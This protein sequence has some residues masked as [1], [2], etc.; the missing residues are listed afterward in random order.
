ML[1]FTLA[2]AGNIELAHQARLLDAQ[3]EPIDGTVDLAVSLWNSEMGTAPADLAWRGTFS[4]TPVSS[5]YVSV[6][7][8]GTDAL[9]SSVLDTPELWVQH[10]LG[11]AL[12]GRS[13]LYRV[14]IAEVANR[15]PVA[16]SAGGSCDTEGALVFDRSA[17]ALRVCSGTNWLDVTTSAARSLVATN[18]VYAWSDGSTA[19]SCR[20]YLEDTDYAGEGDGMYRIDASGGG[21]SAPV[22]AYCDMTSS[23][24]GWTLIHHGYDGNTV[25]HGTRFA[26]VYDADVPDPLAKNDS[27]NLIPHANYAL[28]TDAEE[29]LFEYRDLSGQLAG[30]HNHQRVEAEG[31]F[32]NLFEASNETNFVPV[33]AREQHGSQRVVSSGARVYWGTCAPYLTAL[34]FE[35]F[36]DGGYHPTGG[37]ACHMNTYGNNG[38]NPA[39]LDF[40]DFTD[41]NGRGSGTVGNQGWGVSANAHVVNIWVR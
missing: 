20:A 30:P 18:G 5:G 27:L 37:G 29:L 32:T 11:A 2:F 16:A 14:P 13:L 31:N 40:A 12:P 21:A 38:H 22:D 3:G 26:T 35:T 7:L 4:Q 23:P 25:N 19:A 6:V 10:E 8:G 36:R 41:G 39:N 33:V 28:I 1:W 9:P 17:Q 34:R 24:G 15:V